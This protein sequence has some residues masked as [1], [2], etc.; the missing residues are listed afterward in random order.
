MLTVWVNYVNSW[1]SWKRRVQDKLRAARNRMDPSKDGA[2]MDHVA[3]II[4][5]RTLVRFMVIPVVRPQ[6]TTH[7]EPE[8]SRRVG[9]TSQN[10]MENGSMIQDGR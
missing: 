10:F 4:K 3:F 1:S 9:A 7:N 6:K 5:G 2:P 8:C